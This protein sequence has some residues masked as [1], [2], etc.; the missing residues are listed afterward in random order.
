[1]MPIRR[2]HGFGQRLLSLLHNTYGD[3]LAAGCR[4]IAALEC[5]EDEQAFWLDLAE[6]W[7]KRQEAMQG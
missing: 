1:M 5:D 6:Q 3:K 2:D 7:E 4:N